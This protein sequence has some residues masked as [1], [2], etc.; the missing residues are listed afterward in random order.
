MNDGQI[1]LAGILGE[2]TLPPP[3]CPSIYGYDV[4]PAGSFAYD[5][6]GN[7][8]TTPRRYLAGIP[9]QSSSQNAPVTGLD[10][11]GARYFSGAQ[12]RFTSPDP[13]IVTPARMEDPQRFN[14]YAYARNNPFKFIDPNGEDIDFANDTEEGRRK[15]L[16]LITR[17]LSGNEAANIGIRQ[18]KSGA[19]EA[20]VIGGSAVRKDASSAYKQ[21]TGLIGDHS[22]VADVGLIG[23]GLT[24]T[25]KGGALGGLAAAA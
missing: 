4:P 25:F 3:A 19:Y 13:V 23:G 7:L 6:F 10:Y 22:T 15:A 14:L 20:Y 21:L 18:A 12:G 24:A 1:Y 17:N 2:T 9:T 11:F 8:R 16:A 5:G